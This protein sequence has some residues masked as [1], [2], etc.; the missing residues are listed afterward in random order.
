MLS[1]KRQEEPALQKILKSGLFQFIVVVLLGISVTYFVVQSDRPQQWIQKINRFASVSPNPTQKRS[2]E[3]EA[4]LSEDQSDAEE[5]PPVTWS[6]RS[7]TTASPTETAANDGT[8]R[9]GA[10]SQETANLVAQQIAAKI[11]LIE[12]DG[13]YLNSLVSQAHSRNS[14]IQD[15]EIK[16][17]ILTLPSINS[18]K[19]LD[20]T[21]LQ[22]KKG[23]SENKIYGQQGHGLA[24]DML[25]NQ[26]EN[27]P[28]VFKIA[29][30]K[31]HPNDDFSLDNEYSLRK[32][33]RLILAG[34]RLLSY[35]E[36]D[37]DL[38]NTPPFQIFKSADYRNQKTTFAIIIEL[39]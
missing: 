24:I 1:F 7:T 21:S 36:F 15:A 4:G 18:T 32:G 2:P 38:A 14:V 13:E 39:Q 5:P 35:F 23:S 16:I 33:E 28:P 37:N 34:P 31:N 19:V 25:F 12:V 27:Q 22:L 11:T 20:T 6:A 3:T 10:N 30:N 26:L 9:E 8:T 29:V 17:F